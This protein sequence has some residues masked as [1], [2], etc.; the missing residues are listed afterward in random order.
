MY[1]ILCFLFFLLDSLLLFFSLKVHFTECIHRDRASEKLRKFSKSCFK[2][3]SV[4]R[5]FTIH[6]S[7]AL[8][9]AIK[10]RFGGC[11]FKDGRVE[12]QG[13]GTPPGWPEWSLWGSA[14]RLPLALCA[15][16]LGGRLRT[17]ASG[18]CL[19]CW[20]VDMGVTGSAPAPLSRHE[21]CPR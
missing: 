4:P 20:P 16:R 15:R 17:L 9:N 10:G 8:S 1:D 5:P 6:T 21:P 7:W 19:G 3:A 11:Y 12:I 14:H 2:G 18:V 13:V